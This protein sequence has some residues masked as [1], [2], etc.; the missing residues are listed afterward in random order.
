LVLGNA[1]AETRELK[2]QV[3]ER[4]LERKSSRNKKGATMVA[5]FFWFET[6]Q[7]LLTYRELPA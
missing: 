3:Q 2:K 4:N 6:M 5:P 7:L 1:N